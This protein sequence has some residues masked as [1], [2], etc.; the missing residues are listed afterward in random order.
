MKKLAGL[1]SLLLMFT[2]VIS[3]CGTK[4][5]SASSTENL[6][7]K[8]GILKNVTH[9]PG[10]VALQNGY[11][12]NGFG[13]NVKIEVTGFDNGSDFST[14]MATNQIDIGFVGPGPAINQ[15]LKSKNFRVI[16][17]SNNGGAV[18]IARKD[19]GIKSVKDLVGKTVAIPTK[20]STNEI[21][22]RLL[23]QQEGLKVS[24][25]TSGVQMITRAPAD[26]L[27]AIRQKEVD[28]TLIPEPWGTQMVEEGIGQVL[29]DWDKI[30][31]NNGDYPLTLLLAS[32]DFL[33]NHRDLA[34][35]A[36][37]ANLDGINFI[38][39]N[40][41]KAYDLV[42]AELKELSGKGMDAKLIKAALDHLKLTDEVNADAIK[43]M[44]KVSFDAG[45]IK[46]L[47][48]DELDLSKFIDLSLL[49]EVKKEK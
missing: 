17:G 38:K 46:G 1:L 12:Q 47:K 11:F 22:L 8:V 30:P 24:T 3:A 9:A 44:A 43:A 36:I 28:A 48:E 6:T 21:S 42:S 19:A 26:T 27:V 33:K 18:L 25:D 13:K 16:S 34:K 41:T 5:N 14:A 4:S 20:G 23:L 39:E 32:D 15:Y 37:K 10:F 49:N 40:P 7:V 29:V 2:L 45:Y 35:K 31:P